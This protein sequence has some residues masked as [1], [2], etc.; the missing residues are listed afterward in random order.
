MTVRPSIFLV[1]RP[2]IKV[3]NDWERMWIS[4]GE[5]LSLV[6]AT[7]GSTQALKAAAWADHTLTHCGANV[8]VVT[9]LGL[10]TTDN[11]VMSHGLFHFTAERQSVVLQT[12]WQRTYEHAESALKQTRQLLSHLNV[13]ECRILEDSQPADAII[14]Y[15]EKRPVDT[16]V[17]GRRGHTRL[18][19]LLG[20]LS[21]SLMQESSIPVT[22]VGSY[23]LNEDMFRDRGYSS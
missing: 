15:S 18:G 20:S 9:V 5:L 10:A 23:F 3:T 6:L 8:Y 13:V 19:N 16:I 17:V 21:F 7:D 22:V 2:T 4:V 11:D 14:A 12:A 1:R